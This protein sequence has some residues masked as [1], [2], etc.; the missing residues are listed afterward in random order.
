MRFDSTFVVLT[1]SLSTILALGSS[2]A[3][4]REKGSRTTLGS[5]RLLP[6]GAM[7]VSRGCANVSVQVQAGRDRACADQPARD[8]YP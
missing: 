8:A 7:P 2:L 5:T 4:G 1:L 6:G 3:F